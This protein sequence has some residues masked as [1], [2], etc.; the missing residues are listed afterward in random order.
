MENH[1]A[2]PLK[3]QLK[4]VAITR[5]MYPEITITMPTPTVGPE[6]VEFSLKAGPVTLLSINVDG[7]GKFRM[8]AA[9]GT[10]IAG[11]IPQT[12]NTNTRVSFGGDVCDFL[13]AWCEA[14]PTHHLA[15]GVGHHLETL[16]KFSK[17]SGIELLEI[18]TP[19]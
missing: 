15:L 14:G 13:T 18:H 1:P 19:Q 7:N 16:R 8:I 10:S 12:G 17:L 9:E 2:F 3:D 4:M 5:I 6:N 11:E